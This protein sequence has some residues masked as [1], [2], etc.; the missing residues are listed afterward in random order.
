MAD[1]TILIKVQMEG[2]EQAAKQ[3]T[4]LTKAIDKQ[5]ISIAKLREENKRLT[6]ERN[7]VNINTE[8]GR[9]KLKEYNDQL[10]QNNKRIKEN[11]DQ[12]TKQK[13]GIGDYKG[14]LDKLIPGLGA[15]AEGFS[16]LNVRMKALLA[17]P[18][19]AVLG[20]V[21][22]ALGALTAYFKGTG[23]GQDKLTALTKTAGVVWE[24][25]KRIVES[26]G[27]VIFKTLEFV[28]RV[29]EEIIGFVS[30]A[31]KAAIEAA[32][33]AGQA[34][35]DLDDQIDERETGLI[36]RR[37]EVQN[38]VAKLR[39]QAL[40][41][42]G[43]QKEATI[44]Q[45]IALERELAD[46]EIALSKMRLELF[47]K[48]HATKK[49][50]TDEEKKERAELSAA[51]I[52]ADTEAYS[53]TLRFEKEIEKI[54]DDNHKAHMERLAIE[55]AERHAISQGAV[56]ETQDI[57]VQKQEIEGVSS[58]LSKERMEADLANT[59]KKRLDA[60]KKAQDAANKAQKDETRIAQ[61]ENQARLMIISNTL[62]QAQALFEKDSI[63][64]KFLGIARATVDTYTAANLALA[65]YPPPFG[66]IA[67]GV[68][69]ATGL[70]NVAKIS[71]VGF[72]EGGYTGEGGKYEP[73][74]VV[75]R[76][77][78]VVPQ[79]IVKNP[80]YSGYIESLE[81]ARVGYADG[82]LVT[83]SASRDIVGN[84][85]MAEMF[86]KMNIWVSV[87][88]IR[89]ASRDQEVKIAMSSL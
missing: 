37:A 10:D 55:R 16:E 79:H 74:G 51:I 29:A 42:E 76:G 82:G 49:D 73:A 14:A 43:A 52:A 21:G 67:A 68:A 81:R 28:G 72:A 32:K 47:D 30:P 15:T 48:E 86:Q 75:H 39:T 70:A 65:T 11:V 12:Y 7:A 3:T 78:Y 9:A 19:V 25:F 17:N 56:T 89:Q 27:A 5:E 88:E 60:S 13:I 61:L 69:I 23:E 57:E 38:Q 2:A 8:E 35:A 85:A 1:E 36:T 58:L 63:E 26:V 44:K 84:A 20:A 18:M 83:N 77:E 71:G 66:A 33:A 50:L 45:A 31:S 53:N 41:E 64:H 46:N 24:G 34:I 54:R 4:D 80:I 87:Q 59:V 22:L 6:K 62:G 40:Q